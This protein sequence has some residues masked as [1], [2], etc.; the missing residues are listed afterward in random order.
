MSF[1]RERSFEYPFGK[2]WVYASVFMSAIAIVAAVFMLNGEGP[3]ALLSYFS[4]TFLA[5]VVVLVLKFYLYSSKA[6]EPLEASSFEDEKELPRKRRWSF[7][8][9]LCLAIVALFVPLVLLMVLEPLWW[10]ICITGYVP[11]VNIPEIVL[12]LYSRRSA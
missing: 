4:F 5:T 10:V 6:R 7:M 1:S 9:L 11:A 2:R 12:Y 8:L 3:S